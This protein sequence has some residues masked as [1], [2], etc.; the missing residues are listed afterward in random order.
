[1]KVSTVRVVIGLC[2][3]G[4]VTPLRG[5]SQTGESL[6]I[7]GGLVPPSSFHPTGA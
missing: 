5:P 7:I 1:M 3:F 2:C 6:S 4:S